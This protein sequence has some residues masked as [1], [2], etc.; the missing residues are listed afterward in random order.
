MLICVKMH[1]YLLIAIGMYYDLL[2]AIEN[3]DLNHYME[4]IDKYIGMIKV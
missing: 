3:D 2:I 4:L 1:E